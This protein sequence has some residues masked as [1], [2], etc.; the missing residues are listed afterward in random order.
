MKL[1]MLLTLVLTL[2]LSSVSLA[3]TDQTLKSIMQGLA[4]SMN[5]LNQGIFYENFKLIEQSAVHLYDHPKPKTQLPI[6]AKTL[7]KRMMQFKATDTK[8]HDAAVEI[9]T[10]ARNKDLNGVVKKYNI[11]LK[12]CV[13]CHT[14]FRKEISKALAK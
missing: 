3:G 11:I 5:T 12:N 8:V 2:S 9:V 7:G 1:K 4:K 14:Q 6:V 10:L 13:A